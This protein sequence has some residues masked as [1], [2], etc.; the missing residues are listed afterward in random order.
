MV[1]VRTVVGHDGDGDG[2]D[3]IGLVD[4][5]R[6]VEVVVQLVAGDGGGGQRERER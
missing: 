2:E 5:V 3:L 1:M 6:V 4:A